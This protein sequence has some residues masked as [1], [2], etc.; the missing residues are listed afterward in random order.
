MVGGGIPLLFLYALFILLG[1]FLTGRPVA[2]DEPPHVLL[3]S[4]SSS[5]HSRHNLRKQKDRLAAVSP[6]HDQVVWS[7]SCALPLPTPA[8]QTQRAEASGEERKSGWER[9]LPSSP[10]AT[11]TRLKFAV[12]RNAEEVSASRGPAVMSAFDAKRS[13]GEHL[14]VTQGSAFK[15]L[16]RI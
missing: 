12:N 4:R 8:E 13:G 2:R 1:A 3:P 5:G 9:D 16:S 7:G 10:Y 11:T 15:Y 14:N 6:K